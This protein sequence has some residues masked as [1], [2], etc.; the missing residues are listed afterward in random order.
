MLTPSYDTDT[1]GVQVGNR[2]GIAE[3]EPITLETCAIR[4]M[5]PPGGGSMHG[6]KYFFR[7]NMAATNMYVSRLKKL[8]K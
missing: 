1:L 2:A 6:E 5:D 7:K 3:E 8:E 4:N